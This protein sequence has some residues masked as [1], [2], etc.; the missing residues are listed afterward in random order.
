MK[1]SFSAGSTDNFYDIMGLASLRMKTKMTAAVFL[2]KTSC[3]AFTTCATHASDTSQRPP[4]LMPTSN[5]G[6]RPR[7]RL[8]SHCDY[9]APVINP[10]RQGKMDEELSKMIATDFQPFKIVEEKERIQEIWQC[11]QSFLRFTI[12]DDSV[13][14]SFEYLPQG[15]SA[16]Q[17]EG[18]QSVK[19]QNVG[20]QGPQLHS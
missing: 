16:T 18:H 14:D 17:G 7:T 1:I 3:Q 11:S 4:S 5:V 20:H 12:K 10:L 15:S 9:A 6:T 2:A 8:T 19:L 13:T